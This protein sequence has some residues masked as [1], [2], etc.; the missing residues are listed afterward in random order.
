MINHDVGF[1]RCECGLVY[2]VTSTGKYIPITRSFS[3]LTGKHSGW[4]D[5]LGHSEKMSD[6]EVKDYMNV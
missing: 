1:Y 4:S 2:E 6:K 5:C 3:Q